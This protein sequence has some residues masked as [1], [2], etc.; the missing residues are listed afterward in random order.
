MAMRVLSIDPGLGGALALSD[1][2]DLLDV[3]DMP[4]IDAGRRREIDTHEI[5][6]L[7]VEVGPVAM[8]VL[9]QV[10]TRPGE[11][12]MGAFAFGRGLG[13]IE[14][15]LAALGRPTT[16]VQ[17]SAWKKAVGIATGSG[18]DAS[19]ARAR[20]LWPDEA[21]RFARKKDDGRAD[22]CLIGRWWL[23]RPFNEQENAA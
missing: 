17:P 6:A 5:V 20:Q 8:V 7:L 21:D 1:G 22:A 4:T 23:M 16:A 10:G 11:G 15:A 18:K 9:E 12:A 13:R 14:G 3:W 2:L 19:R